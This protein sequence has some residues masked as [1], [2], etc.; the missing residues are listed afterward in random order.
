M[1]SQRKLSR[2]ILALLPE[3]LRL[4]ILRRMAKINM[5]W[6]SSSLEIK[7]AET[8]VELAEAYRLLHDSYI[9]SGF[10]DPDP[11]GMRVLAQHLLPQTTTIIAKWDGKV[12][13]TL[14]LIRDNP[15]GLPMEK[16]FSMRRLAEVSSLAIH[17]DY[18][19]QAYLALF[20]L[21]RFVY[22]YAKHY[23]GTDEL[24]IA[25]NPSTTDMYTAFIGFEKL[26]SKAKAY[27]FVK[28]APAVGL[29]LDFSTCES[30]SEKIFSKRSDSQNF[31]KYWLKAETHENNRLPKRTYHTAS[32]PILTPEL[33]KGFFLDRA[34]MARKLS[35]QDIQILLSVYPYLNYK[36]VL[37]G[38]NTALLRKNARLETQMR[39]EYGDEK[40]V[41]DVWNV[42]SDG[43]LLRTQPQALNI[44]EKSQISVW[45]N[46]NDMI[47]LEVEVRWCSQQSLY[48]LRILNSEPKWMIMIQSLESEYERKNTRSLRVA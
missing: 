27:D 37:E 21:F 13:G 33:L 30:R 38:L 35:F 7:I 22:Q 26:V 48:G 17:P 29:F 34:Q 24:V 41:C 6:P 28:G 36:K 43:L 5:Q 11:S 45:V 3:K 44:N 19:G 23:F 32:D 2:K 25:V 10:A 14:S 9:N 46:E 39:S 4:A 31:Y 8:E 42:S 47:R 15:F 16:I 20:P 12:V 40:I 18:R 1:R